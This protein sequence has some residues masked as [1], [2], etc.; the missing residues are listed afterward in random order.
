M[1]PIKHFCPKCNGPLTVESIADAKR[2]NIVRVEVACSK[3]GKGSSPVSGVTL[4]EA[5]NGKISGAKSIV[6]VKATHAA[7]ESLKS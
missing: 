3:C 6:L 5:T 2:E 7:I 1:Q 4:A